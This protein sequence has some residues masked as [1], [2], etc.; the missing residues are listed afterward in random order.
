[1]N[2]RLF[3]TCDFQDL[4]IEK[5]LDR[6]SNFI[7]YNPDDLNRTILK[8]V[9]ERSISEL[10]NQPIDEIDKKFESYAKI[11]LYSEGKTGIHLKTEYCNIF[12]PDVDINAINQINAENCYTTA[13]FSKI[14]EFLKDSVKL[15]ELIDKNEV[16]RLKY[17]LSK[18]TDYAIYAA[19]YYLS[20]HKRPNKEELEKFKNSI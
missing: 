8:N 3:F 13:F 16:Q 9:I 7:R 6:L 19:I 15:K 2:E 11:R 17:I 5:I 20:N 10:I 1:M 18:C 12:I 14:N 4:L